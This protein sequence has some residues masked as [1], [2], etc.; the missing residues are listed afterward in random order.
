MIRNFPYT[1]PVGICILS[2]SLGYK[3]TTKEGMIF[4]SKKKNIPIICLLN[5]FGSI[6]LT[7]FSRLCNSFFLFYKK[8]RKILSFCP[9]IRNEKIRLITVN[10]HINAKNR[11]KARR[12]LFDF[13]SV[14]NVRKK[15]NLTSALNC[16]VK[17]S[18]VFCTCARYSSGKNFAALADELAKLC[19][20]LV[21]DKGNLISAEDTYLF[22][23]CTHS[24]A[25]RTSVLCSIHLMKSSKLNFLDGVPYQKGRS[26]SVLISSNLGA[27]PTGV[28]N[29]GAAK[30]S[31]AP[32]EDSERLSTNITSSATMSVL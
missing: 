3:C 25:C 24:R 29:A 2:N 27:L 23:L 26:S 6:I 21:V 28:A 9:K 1:I 13:K 32:F 12:F 11:R 7:Q 8:S 31:S 5:L 17:L 14:G 15:C 22:S 10:P 4:L 20:I 30:A 16:C 19:R 18:L